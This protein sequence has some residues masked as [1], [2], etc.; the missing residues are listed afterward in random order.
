MVRTR[1][2]NLQAGLEI[3]ASCSPFALRCRCGG[4]LLGGNLFTRYQHHFAISDT[5][6]HVYIDQTEQFG[7]AKPGASE[8][9]GLGQ[10]ADTSRAA[11]SPRHDLR[12]NMSMDAIHPVARLARVGAVFALLAT[13]SLSS[14]TPAAEP[15]S[16][17]AVKAAY[18]YRF[19]GYIDWPERRSL[20]TPFVID[21]LGAPGIARELR[22]LLPGHPIRDRVAQVREIT[23]SD[24]VGNAR[25]VYVAAG[26]TA[27]LRTLIPQASSA[28]MLLVTDEE[29]GLSAGSTLNFV[30]ID[31]NVRFEASLSAAARSGLKIS[32]ELLGVAIRVQGR[33]GQSFLRCGPSSNIDEIRGICEPRMAHQ[34]SRRPHNLS[35]RG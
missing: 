3:G 20:D 35:R 30:T 32:S 28:S 8:L 4:F 21:V 15:H 12:S 22:R 23:G 17:D 34:G 16:E 19:A 27:L 31:R 6:A 29:N 26:H 24:D 18:L 11:S 13:S 10:A 1:R 25:I 5:Q 9:L 33:E 7:P 2:V 14:P